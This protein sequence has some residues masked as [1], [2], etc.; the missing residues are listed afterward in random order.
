[1]SLLGDGELER[2]AI[3][4]NCRMSRERNFASPVRLGQEGRPPAQDVQGAPT[5][6]YKIGKSD[7][8]ALTL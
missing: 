2:S 5:T 7:H 1:M 6:F 4:A 3:V 8:S